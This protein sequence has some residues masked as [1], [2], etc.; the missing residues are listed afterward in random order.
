ANAAV[1]R[2]LREVANARV[3]ATTCEVPAERLAIEAPLLQ[4]LPTPYGGRSLR[5]VDPPARKAIMG[6]Q[7]PLAV[8]DE[9]FLREVPHERS[10]ARAYR[11]A[12]W[13]AEADGT[14]GSVRSDR[15]GRGEAQG[16]KLRRLPGRSAARRARDPAGEIARDA[17]ANGGL[18]PALKTL[19]AY[20]FAFA[21]GA[22]R[23]DPGTR[24]PRLRRAH[25]EC[26]AARPLR[27][28]QDAPCHR[29]WPAGCAQGLEGPLHVGRRP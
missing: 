15:A 26:R 4:P 7:H 14:P 28:G 5:S 17:D 21:T 3:H 13:R 25:R 2:W 6:Y 19:E 20:D 11:D 8:Y 10:A 9:L 12:G 24:V 29:L 1:G 23:P 22:P 16:G 27:H 18:S